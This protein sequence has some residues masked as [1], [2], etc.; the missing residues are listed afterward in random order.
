MLGHAAYR[1]QRCLEKKRKSDNLK[2]GKSGALIDT[3]LHSP[4]ARPVPLL[5][6]S[7]STLPTPHC[8]TKIEIIG[9]LER[10]PRPA[11]KIYKISQTLGILKDAS[12]VQLEISTTGTL[13]LT[14]D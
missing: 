8:R 1:N 5:L 7:L 14:D 10:Y 4:T 6:P 3:Y 2:Y 12:G 11:P 13:L 9:S